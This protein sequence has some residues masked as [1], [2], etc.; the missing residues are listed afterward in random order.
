MKFS[1]RFMFFASF[2]F[3]P[4]RHSPY[5]NITKESRFKPVK[6]KMA[7][8]KNYRMLLNDA[9]TS[10]QVDR[11]NVQFIEQQAAGQKWTV[12]LVYGGDKYRSACTFTCTGQTK[13]HAKEA[14]CQQ[15]LLTSKEEL[16]YQLV[17]HDFESSNEE[18][19]EGTE[20]D[21][22]KIIASP[23]SG[24]V[25]LN[26]YLQSI[27][28]KM[29]Q[30]ETRTETII[31]VQ[32]AGLLS[33]MDVH[34]LL[35]LM[36]QTT[37]QKK[38][39]NLACSMLFSQRTVLFKPDLIELGKDIKLVVETT[40]KKGG[41]PS[42]RSLWQEFVQTSVV[43]STLE[44]DRKKD[45][46]V[47]KKKKEKKRTILFTDSAI[48]VDRWLLDHPAHVYGLDCEAAR[49][50]S[51]CTI[52]IAT[53]TPPGDCLVYHVYNQTYKNI[54]PRLIDVLEDPGVCKLVVCG[55]HD[56]QW[57]QNLVSKLCGL[58]DLGKEAERFGFNRS[59]GLTRLVRWS[60]RM[61]GKHIDDMPDCQ[62]ADWKD[63]QRLTQEQILY[64]AGDAHFAASL[65][66]TPAFAAYDAV[67]NGHVNWDASLSFFFCS[68]L[69]P[70][71]N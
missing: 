10:G 31:H 70:S 42:E 69:T 24:T 64:A 16:V 27:G 71:S 58:V 17:Y 61:E 3:F 41:A 62:L 45:T 20:E 33:P 52:Q 15:F 40:E 4:P 43:Q 63:A 54:S 6:E 12:K 2:L 34:G 11:R 21:E 7:A 51:L 66:M 5:T 65:C 44:D 14:V 68:T 50:G 30:L 46:M 60:W 13:A 53:A 37:S 25:Q 49:R 22:T 1:L 67:A 23:G 36:K 35:F 56:Q 29:P 26:E 8:G 57:L 48:E 55:D 32:H 47:D 59:A 19:E 28:L 18:E 39:K 9:F 38:A